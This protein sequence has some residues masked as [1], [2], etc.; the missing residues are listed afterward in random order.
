M[1]ILDR[2]I[3]KNPL[4]LWLSKWGW[5]RATTPVAVFARE[6]MAERNN[7][8]VDWKEEK[9]SKGSRDFLSRF[10]E[11][12]TK[13]SEFMSQQRV[14]AVTVANMFAGS[15]TT[16]ITLR[17][18]FY[19]LLCNPETMK[20]LRQ[21]L[22]RDA[23]FDE[24]GLATWS[25]VHEL[26]YLSAVIKEGLRCH[27]AA[28]L[29]LERVVPST[30]LTI[31][32]Y[33]IPPGTIVGCNAWVIHQSE[34]V[35]G[36]HTELFRPERWLEADEAQRNGMN[37]MLFSFGAGTRSCIG[38]NISLLEMYKLVPALL[39]RFEVSLD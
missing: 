7:E 31:G 12:H 17:A 3:V 16:A 1:P 30:G 11:A 2:L 10:Q 21:E 27:P 4:R 36:D 29:S 22:D 32:S 23:V 25:N 9:M 5:G 26:P 8:Q 14:L 33:S 28:G 24:D 20:R 6:R 18:I 19:H 38:K 13:D 39:H 35:F 15:D 37:N 34:S